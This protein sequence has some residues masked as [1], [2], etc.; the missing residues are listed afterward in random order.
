MP[1]IAG[2]SVEVEIEGVRVCG[3]VAAVHVDHDCKRFIINASLSPDVLALRIFEAVQEVMRYSG[4]VPLL[5]DDLR[6]ADELL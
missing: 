3:R 1:T 5:A 4:V 6:L 2:Y